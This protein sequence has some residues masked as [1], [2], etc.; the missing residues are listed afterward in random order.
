ML[1]GEKNE[2]EKGMEKEEEEL[3]IF[4]L[5]NNSISNDF[6]VFSSFLNILNYMMNE[7][8]CILTLYIP[9]WRLEAKLIE[10]EPLRF[11]KIR[12]KFYTQIII[13]T[14]FQ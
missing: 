2:D 14:M 3:L 6:Y 7:L 4:R 11:Y 9:Y 1:E 5:L 10:F 12:T 8:L 13:R